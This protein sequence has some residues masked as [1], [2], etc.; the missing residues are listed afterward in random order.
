MAENREN[1]LRK[2]KKENVREKT[3]KKGWKIKMKKWEHKK[4]EKHE[5]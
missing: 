2:I 3:D 5:N 1:K 4:N